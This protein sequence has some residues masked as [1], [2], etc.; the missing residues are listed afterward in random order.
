MRKIEEIFFSSLISPLSMPFFT[1]S[2]D[3]VDRLS[4]HIIMPW[5]KYIVG[6]AILALRCTRSRDKLYFLSLY[7]WH[8][9]LL[10]KTYVWENMSKDTFDMPSRCFLGRSNT[11]NYYNSFDLLLELQSMNL[12]EM[13]PRILP[14]NRTSASDSPWIFNKPTHHRYD[15]TV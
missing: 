15:E 4:L 10:P 5:H 7:V 13:Y 14:K 2:N 6:Y 12:F 1:R 8:N 11:N 9:Y 3:N